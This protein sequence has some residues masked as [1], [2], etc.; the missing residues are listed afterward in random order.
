MNINQHILIIGIMK[1]IL[2][3]KIKI[4]SLL[5][6]CICSIGLDA[7]GIRQ[8]PDNTSLEFR[9]KLL[10]EQLIYYK[11][12]LTSRLES[13]LFKEVCEMNN[14]NI[15]TDSCI[16]KVIFPD[17]SGVITFQA[18]A[19]YLQD[20]NADKLLTKWK[21]KDYFSEYELIIGPE[22][23]DE[24]KK[25][26]IRLLKV[27]DFYVSDDLDNYIDSVRKVETKKILIEFDKK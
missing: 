1:T 15:K 16:K 26:N 10:E 8:T 21:N 9:L 7:Q 25:G 23:V 18:G 14:I 24:N 27:L 13:S 17:Y 2:R 11:K 3:N 22:A 12:F 5:A 4:I 6:C 20:E 19:I